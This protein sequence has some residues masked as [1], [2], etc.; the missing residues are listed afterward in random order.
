MAST[1]S[2]ASAE[3]LEI[4]ARLDKIAARKQLIGK[5]IPYFGVAFL[6]MFFSIVTGGKFLSGANLVNMIEQCFT[7]AII[8]TGASFV[9]SH[10][11]MDFSI[12]AA[13]GVAQ[14]CGALL[15][16]RVGLPFPVAMLVTLVVPIGTCLM[17]FLISVVFKVPVFIGSMCIRSLLMGLLTIGV[18]KA[19]IIIPVSQYP[20]MSNGLVKAV[21]LAVVISIGVYLFHFTPIGKWGRSIGGNRNTAKQAG[22][23]VTNQMM[24]A[25]IFLG[26]CVGIA[27]MFQMFRA[28]T[29]SVNSGTG[30]EFNIML[31]IVLGGFPMSGGEKA[32]VPSAVIGAVTA[33]LLVN[34][35]ALWGLDANL[36]NG[37]KGLIFIIMIALSYDRSAGKLVN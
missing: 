31:A 16:L 29:I 12:G 36:V 1:T 5:I 24:L 11:N 15:L 32:S 7:M 37:V 21:I 26:A 2:R 30:I 4:Q 22:I 8:A 20:F 27:A 13:C 6:L 17:V 33:T 23:K 14:M 19:E 9:Y 18:S 28:S 10:G 3:N 25:Y 35:L 34:G